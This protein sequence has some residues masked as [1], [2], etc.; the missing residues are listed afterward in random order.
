MGAVCDIPL[1]DERVRSKM[2]KSCITKW[3]IDKNNRESDMAVILREKTLRD[4]VGKRS[5]F[6]V[7]GKPVEIQEIMRYVKRRGTKQNPAFRVASPSVTTPSYIVCST[8]SPAPSPMEDRQEN[9]ASPVD[10]EMWEL[11]VQIVQNGLNNAITAEEQWLNQDVDQQSTLQ[12]MDIQP[13]HQ[14]S[15][16]KP[17]V[18]QTM[19][20]P[21]VLLIR[22]QLFS[23]IKTYFSGSFDKKNWVTDDRGQCINI[24]TNGTDIDLN[25]FSN[26]CTLAGSLMNMRYF[27][28]GRQV[29]SKG[30][31]PLED[32]LKAEKP[33]TLSDI[34][35]ALLLLKHR[36]L[37]EV[38][39]Q[40]QRYI[41]KMAANVLP[42][43]HPWSQICRLLEFFTTDDLESVSTRSWECISDVFEQKLGLFHLTTLECRTDFITRTHRRDQVSAERQLRKLL[44][45]CRQYCGTFDSRYLEI[46]SKFAHSLYK[47]G[48]YTEVEV[49]GKELVK[50]AQEV[51]NLWYK[52]YAL[53]L[54]ARAQYQLDKV[55]LAEKKYAR[56][57]RNT[58]LYSI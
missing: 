53:D 56:R 35:D 31:A 51:G 23:S 14:W 54:S 3:K 37:A 49:L 58:H 44:S 4:A 48:Q 40:M 50:L 57:Y 43:G 45:G 36:R 39:A 18:P 8:P 29:L 16:L 55:Q 10:T 11:A 5:S 41:S 32:I 9:P 13:F 19:S 34:L 52:E 26:S 28:E 6:R 7:R 20:P 2:Y 47:Q 15:S 22:E 25:V 12:Y 33:R 17:E 24:A 30:F 1:T 42:E 21:Q 38:A 27:V 46:M